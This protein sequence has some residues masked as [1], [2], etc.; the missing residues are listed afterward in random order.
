[1]ALRG[2]GEAVLPFPKGV[3]SAADAFPPL[4]AAVG[5]AILIG[6][7]VAISPLASHG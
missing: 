2:S 6:E 1:M 5:G 3:Y 7:T 4:K